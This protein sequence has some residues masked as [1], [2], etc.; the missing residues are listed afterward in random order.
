M[1][2]GYA[3]LFNDHLTHQNLAILYQVCLYNTTWNVYITITTT[4]F[5]KRLINNVY[6]GKTSHHGPPMKTP[7]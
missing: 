7:P 1:P 6:T 2:V 3:N 4:H 5:I